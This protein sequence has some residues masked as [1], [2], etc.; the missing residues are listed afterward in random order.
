VAGTPPVVVA[1]VDY[2]AGMRIDFFWDPVC[3][4]C[5]L[6]SRWIH[7]VMPHRDLEVDWRFISLRIINDE[8][9]Y[10]GKPPLYQE[11]HAMGRSLLRVAA[12][13]RKELGPEPIGDLY[14]AY[15]THIWHH[16]PVEGGSRA[17]TTGI[18]REDVESL[19][20]GVGLDAR[21]AESMDDVSLDDVLREDT[22]LAFSRT[23]PNVG[24]PIIT[25]G[26]PDGPSY[27]G[28]VI[29]R[30]PPQEEALKLWD[31]MVA[32]SQVWSFAEVKRSMRERPQ[33]PLLSE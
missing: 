23:G 3:P 28:P 9:G 22:E 7:E 24:T 26:A 29:S 20:G 16:P 21:F 33:L 11:S 6:T 2:R 10:E 13:V 4:Y 32:L 14:T 12:A 27:F 5:W 30:V 17:H 15:G 19:L 1:P 8:I 18:T 25:Y 31:S